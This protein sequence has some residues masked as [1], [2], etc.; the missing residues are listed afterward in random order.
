[1]KTVMTT[2]LLALSTYLVA[3]QMTM[4]EPLTLRNDVSYDLLGEVGGH[5]LLFRDQGVEFEVVAFDRKMQERWREKIELDKRQ[6]KVLDIIPEE[7]GFSIVYK[8]R[9][10]SDLITKLHRYGPAANLIDSVTIKNYGALFYN[11]AITVVRSD[12]RSKVL[13][14]YVEKQ[15][16]FRMVSF[17]LENSEVIWESSFSPS[18][19]SYYQHFRQLLVDNDGN[20]ILVLEKNNYRNQRETHYYEFHCYYGADESLVRFNIPMQGRLTYDAQ[21]TYD[22]LNERLVGA[23]FYSEK[24][25]GRADGT[26]YLSIPIQEHED[27]LLAFNSFDEAFLLTLLGKDADKNRGATDLEI[28]ELVLRRDGG[29]LMIG[30]HIRS[31]DRR[32]ASTNR[33]YYDNN[34]GRFAVD[35][36]YE[37]ILAL[38]IHPDGRY[39]WGNVLHKRQY[40]QDDNGIFSS[41]FLFRTGSNLRFLF[42][43]EIKYENT[44][45]EYVLNGNGSSERNSLLSTERLKLRLRFRD[46]LQLDGDRLVVPSEH[47]NRLKLVRLEY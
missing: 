38:S 5:T 27:H 20:A 44:V 26:F 8:H 46:A 18:S 6:P 29:V 39:H 34:T 40:S 13:I 17:D 41:F 35:H 19:F 22:H 47:R 37:E 10:K 28:R 9:Y 30:E 43:D 21:F 24:N 33:N 23:G 45:S 42:N 15:D 4:S 25:L 1:M 3:Q 32:T 16:I 11:P 14:Y 7:G 36:Y 31:L 2:F 12:D